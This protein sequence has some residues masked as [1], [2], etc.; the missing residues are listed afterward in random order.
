MPNEIGEEVKRHL[1]DLVADNRD[2]IEGGFA[3][4]GGHV[5]YF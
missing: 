3:G 2:V 1:V 5:S 4:D